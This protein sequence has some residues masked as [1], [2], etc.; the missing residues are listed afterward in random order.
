MLFEWRAGLEDDGGGS[1]KVSR[2]LFALRAAERV[3]A[4]K[5]GT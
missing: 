3:E 1:S 4:G 5:G 2:C